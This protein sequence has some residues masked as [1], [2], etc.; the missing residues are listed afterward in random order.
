MLYIFPKHR[1]QGYG[2]ELI[3]H[4]LDKQYD[5]SIVSNN[6]YIHKICKKLN[7]VLFSG[8]EEVPG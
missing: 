4:T 5:L 6:T 1:N 2:K 8:Q 3:K 7:L